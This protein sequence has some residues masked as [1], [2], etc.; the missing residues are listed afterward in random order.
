[1]RR[2]GIVVG[3]FGEGAGIVEFRLEKAEDRAVQ[4][5]AVATAEAI[6]SQRVAA[7]RPPNIRERF[8]R[9]VVTGAADGHGESGKEKIENGKAAV[10]A[11]VARV[12]LAAMRSAAV[13]S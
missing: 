3:G 6:A 7:A 9:L 13:G 2:S 11:S 1:V 10:P 4:G 5:S 8:S 12:K